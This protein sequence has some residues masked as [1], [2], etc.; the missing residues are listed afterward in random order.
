MLG[1]AEHTA[2]DK[3]VKKPR[4]QVASASP[5]LLLVRGHGNKKMR[6]DTE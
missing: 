1:S 4:A 2:E 6:H 5:M 3:E